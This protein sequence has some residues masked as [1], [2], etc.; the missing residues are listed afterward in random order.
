MI[1]ILEYND[2]NDN[3]KKQPVIVIEQIPKVSIKKAD[4]K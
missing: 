3:P 1:T 2:D 4:M